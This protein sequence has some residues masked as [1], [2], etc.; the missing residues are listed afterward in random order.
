MLEIDDLRNSP[1]VSAR[2]ICWIVKISE[3]LNVMNVAEWC[4]VKRTD[5]CP[6]ACPVI[7]CLPAWVGPTCEQIKHVYRA[8][9]QTKETMGEAHRLT[10]I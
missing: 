5:V 3:N 9:R 10:A 1:N 4:F 2:K 8:G 7:F 6:I